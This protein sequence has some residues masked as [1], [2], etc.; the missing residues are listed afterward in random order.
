LLVT[1]GNLRL[2]TLLKYDRNI[3]LSVATPANYREVPDVDVYVFDRYTPA[4]Q[5][6]KPALLLGSPLAAAGVVRQQR[7]TSWSQEHPVMRHV[8][9]QDVSIRN[10][11]KVDP[12]QLTIIAAS[13]DTPLIL[14][15]ENPRRVMLTFDLSSSDFPV[16]A[17]FPVFMH[18]ALAWLSEERPAMHAANPLFFNV[19][20]S[21]LGDAHVT[22]ERASRLHRELWVYMLAAAIVLLMVEWLTYHRRITL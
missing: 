11:A 2:N 3:D 7:I 14:A 5:P 13:N 22:V 19:N 6:S 21:V 4:T 18:N 9:L 15:S 12:Q 16:Q 17:G 20:D 1:P 8:G 10:V